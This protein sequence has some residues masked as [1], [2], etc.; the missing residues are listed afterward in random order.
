MLHVQIEEHPQ[1]HDEHGQRT[2]C[3]NENDGV[4]FKTNL[5]RNSTINQSSRLFYQNPGSVPFEWEKLPGKSKD[6][7][8]A[9]IIPPPSPP[10]AV[11]SLGLST[12]RVRFQSE[13][14]KK[15]SL[16]LF[17]KKCKI[18]LETKK[19]KSRKIDVHNISLASVSSRSLSSRMLRNV[20]AKSAC[21]GAGKPKS[22]VGRPVGDS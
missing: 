15:N 1:T 8:K 10:P 22:I 7:A 5:S 6:P 21:Y 18:N 16:S 9:E 3:A 12:P 13:K 2:A 17:L 11:Q 14:P 20:A 4:L 19:H